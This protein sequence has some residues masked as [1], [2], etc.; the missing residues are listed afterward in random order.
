MVL[1]VFSRVRLF[2]T[3]W[4]V[5]HQVPLSVRFSRHEYWSGLPFPSPRDFPDPGLNPCLLHLLQWLVGSLPLPPPGKPRPRGVTSQLY[6][7]T[8][9]HVTCIFKICFQHVPGRQETL[10]CWRS[11]SKL[12]RVSICL[13]ILG[14][15]TMKSLLFIPLN[16][17]KA[18]NS[19][20]IK[21]LSYNS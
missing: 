12:I 17:K 6:G 5:A 2:V 16:S 18:R 9:S 21:D 10:S 3:P 1:C 19:S 15:I 14:G 7:L 4:T 20:T 13:R 8:I 11:Y